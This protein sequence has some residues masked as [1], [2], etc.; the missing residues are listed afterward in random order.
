M[1]S[2]QMSLVAMAITSIGLVTPRLTE[3]F[4]MSTSQQ[5]MLVGV[6]YAGATAACLL[7]GVFCARY[8]SAFFSRLLL[9]A[10]AAVMLFFGFIPGYASALLGVFLMGLV[11]VGLENSVMVSC[12]DMGEKG[13]FA[14]S[15]V[16]TLFSI[17]AISVPFLFL[18]FGGMGLWR[19]VYFTLSALFLASAIF[20][21]GRPGL[22]G[23]DGFKSV[24]STYAGFLKSPKFLL[25]ALVLLLYVAAEVG[26]WSLMP[27]LVES[28]VGGSL[29]GIISSSL[30]WSMMLVGRTLSTVLMKKLPRRAI[31]LP[32]GVCAVVC[33]AL[34]IF[35]S[36]PAAIVFAALAGF[37]CAP[38]FAFLTSW[39]TELSGD[40]S[41]SYLAFVMAF[42]MLGPVVLGWVVGLL[43]ELVAGRFII[44]PALCCFV[45]MLALYIPLAFGKRKA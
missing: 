15:V 32:S 16:H 10:G 40:S 34:L 27:I 26:L 1:L 44:L 31:L 25:G 43:G 9:F 23:S 3:A 8:G 41:T 22:H 21:R 28:T 14:N 42:G 4:S 36:G 12:L 24:F 30:F 7:G 39:C 38:F 17:G 20:A 5:G 19:P 45:L 2:F 18:F 35:L 29:S 37:F 13:P 11:F 6:L 33:Y